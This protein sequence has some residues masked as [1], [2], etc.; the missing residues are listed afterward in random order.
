MLHPL[1]GKTSTH[2]NNP[3]QSKVYEKLISHT[4][5]SFSEKYGLLPAAQFAYWKG[6]GCTDALLTI[7][8][9][10]PKSCAGMESYIVQLDFSAAFDRVSQL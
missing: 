4:L 6:L 5:S 10:F 3:I 9:H 2:I 7:S 1:I 8:H